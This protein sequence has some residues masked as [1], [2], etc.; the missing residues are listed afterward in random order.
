MKSAFG[1]AVAMA[2]LAGA[3]AAYAQQAAQLDTIIKDGVTIKCRIT[4]ATYQQ[5]TFTPEKKPP[6]T[7]KGSEITSIIFGD[8]PPSFQRAKVAEAEKKV[9]KAANLYEE[10]MKEIDAKKA[11]D[12]NKAPLLLSWAGFQADRGDINGALAILKRIRSECGDSWWRPE[13][14]RKGVEIARLKGIEAQKAVLDEMK[15]EPEPMASEAEMGLAELAATRSEHD[16]ALAIYKKV[17]ANSGSS[18]ADAAKMGVFRTLKITKKNSEL[19][20]YSKKLLDDPATTP[21]LQQA[22]G[23]WAAGSM[24]E[25]AGKDRVKIR[26]AIFAAGKAIAMGPP[27]RKEE[28]ED[29]VA[30]LR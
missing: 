24:L 2:F 8:E 15:A 26:A 17:A 9:D 13:S 19:D 6:E 29:Y 5:V 20:D 18:F 30:A 1:P 14:Y 22:A 25:K 27:D 23:A 21:A 11:R 16:E 10:A 7:V 28:A 12:W 4:K 3:A